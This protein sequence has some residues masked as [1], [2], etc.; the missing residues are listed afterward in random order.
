MIVLVVVVAVLDRVVACGML[1][2]GAVMTG[3]HSRRGAKEHA[4]RDQYGDWPS[5]PTRHQRLA[6]RAA[7]STSPGEDRDDKDRVDDGGRVGNAHRDRLLGTGHVY[8]R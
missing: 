1:M 3:Q 8:R 2:T 7:S 4:D 5:E 6:T